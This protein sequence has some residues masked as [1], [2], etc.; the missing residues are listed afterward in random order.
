MNSAIQG[1]RRGYN[2]KSSTDGF[3]LAIVRLDGRNAR[4]KRMTGSH[5]ASATVLGSISVL[6]LRRHQ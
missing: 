5:P 1:Y 2:L 3:D 4:L 6:L